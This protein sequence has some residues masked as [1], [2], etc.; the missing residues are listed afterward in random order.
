MKTKR[1]QQ[2]TD[3]FMFGNGF[4][5]IDLLVVIAIIGILAVLIF[6]ALQNAQAG[7]RDAQRKSFARD[8]TT[9]EA[10]YYDTNKTYG[11]IIAAAGVK[12]LANP[13]GTPGLQESNSLIGTWPKV[14]PWIPGTVSD[15]ECSGS[16][17]TTGAEWEAH[18]MS[19][20]T[21]SAF[22]LTAPL[23]K[24]GAGTFTCTQSGCHD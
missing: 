3:Q 4:T 22:T 17:V 24:T 2:K 10:M 20:V 21:S 18:A 13:G 9:A 5:L 8:L 7:A 6:L 1:I 12:S 15:T 23:E 16:A 11:H 14:C 19:G